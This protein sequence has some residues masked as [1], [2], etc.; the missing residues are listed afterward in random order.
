MCLYCPLGAKNL[1]FILFIRNPEKEYS[2]REENGLAIQDSRHP[3]SETAGGAVI[4]AMC[5]SVYLVL[6]PLVISI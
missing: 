2:Q 5:F 4:S 3:C 6:T 1:L